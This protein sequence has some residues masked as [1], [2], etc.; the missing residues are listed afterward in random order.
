MSLVLSSSNPMPLASATSRWAGPVT[1]RIGKLWNWSIMR[2]LD[3]AALADIN[4]GALALEERAYKI[5]KVYAQT[6]PAQNMG[7]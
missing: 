1:I 2:D 5:S 7:E 4:A 6:E 3:A